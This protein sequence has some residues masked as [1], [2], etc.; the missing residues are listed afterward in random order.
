MQNATITRL[1]LLAGALC[2]SPVALAETSEDEI[3][4]IVSEMMA[5]ASTRS[6]LLQSGGNAGHDGMFYLADEEGNF[7]LN[8]AGQV[9]FRYTANFGEENNAS[10][11]DDYTGGFQTNRTK[12][13]FTGNAVLPNLVYK[14]QG[15]FAS[16]GGNFSLQDAYVGYAFD[17][18]WTLL[19]G[20]MK[21]P[22]Q[23]E[24]LVD[25]KYQ[26]AADRSFANSLFSPTRTQGIAVNYRN[27]DINFTAGFTDGANAFNT[28]FNQDQQ[29]YAGFPTPASIGGGE[30]DYSFT[31]RLEWKLEG[32]WGQFKDFTSMP[33]SEFA[34]MLGFAGHYEGNETLVGF[35]G[36]PADVTVGGYT[37]DLSLEGDGWN[38][39][40]AFMGFSTDTEGLVDLDLDGAGDDT[41]FAD[42]ALVV[43]GGVFIPDTDWE[44]FARYDGIFLDDDRA[45]EDDFNTLTFGLNWYWSGHA[46]KFTVDATIFL[47]ESLG[48]NGVPL[49][50]AA[51]GLNSF[52]NFVGDDDEGEFALRAQFQLLF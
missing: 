29:N 42:F 18:G 34:A 1:T 6:S 4:A 47:D 17:S 5:D 7:R 31:A 37:V 16:S 49:A 19:W 10:D 25:S 48:A 33:G 23:R 15:N 24:E 28:D 12:L 3:R 11:G 51:G 8:V 21:A 13:E 32:D 20:Q 52:K 35:A 14:V 44:L 22:L 9:Q 39:F 43:Q 40:A 45:G 46:A 36:T 50:A 27:D 26:L 2:V 38:F 41:D 30:A